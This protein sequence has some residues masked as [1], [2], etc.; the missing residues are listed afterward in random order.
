MAFRLLYSKSGMQLE[1]QLADFIQ[2]LSSGDLGD[3]SPSQLNQ[4]DMVQMRT[5]K[6]ERNITEK[7]TK[8]QE[9]VADSTMV[10]LS[11]AVT[12]LMRSDGGVNEEQVE[13]ALMAKEEGLEE[14]LHNADDLCLRTLKA[15][16][17]IVT[18]MQAVHFL[19]LLLSYTSGFMTGGRRRMQ[20]NSM[21]LVE[22]DQL[23]RFANLY[24]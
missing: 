7:I 1:D 3:L 5:I 22:T 16:L 20:G 11:H 2:G 17:D 24:A 8:H 19:L 6:D 9:T 23:V 15:V 21:V 18:P 10:G 4:L 13:L 12:E 14:I